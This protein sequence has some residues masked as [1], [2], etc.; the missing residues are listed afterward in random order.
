MTDRADGFRLTREQDRR[1]KTSDEQVAEIRALYDKGTTQKA[2]AEQ[3][4]ISQSAV[5]YIVSP[6]ASKQLREYRIENPP[7]RRTKDEA[8]AYMRSLRKY[9]REILKNGNG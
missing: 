1:A 5:C 8:A 7:K 3:F 4:H 9:K 6:R 2:I